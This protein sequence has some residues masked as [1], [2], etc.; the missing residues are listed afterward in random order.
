MINAISL[1]NLMEVM[2]MMAVT[3]QL[4]ADFYRTCA[5]TWEEDRPFWMAIVSEEEKH[6]S[7]IDK[8]ARIISFKPERFEIGRPFNQTAIRTIMTGVEGHLKR[9]QEGMIPRDRLMVVARDIEASVIEKNYSEIVRTTDVEYLDLMNEITKETC[10]HK[11]SIEQ[12]IQ[13]LKRG[14]KS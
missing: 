9:L 6:A 1:Q 2:K 12:R 5:E 8:M 7:N 4:I 13:E 10:D 3:E 14:E 11:T